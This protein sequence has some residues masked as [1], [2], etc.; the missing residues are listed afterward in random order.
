[1]EITGKIIQVLPPVSGTSKAGNT[2]KKREYVLETQ[3][4]YPKKVFFDFFGD[5]ADQYPLEGGQTIKLS[6]DIESR[7]YNGRWYTS[8]RGW[9]A[10][11]LDGAAPAQQ[12]MDANYPPV[13]FPPAPVGEPS[14]SGSDDLP[15]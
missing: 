7:E 13:D 2:W 10:E 3:E 11:H 1:M 12:P 5:R 15:F 6:F 4:T 9:K 8:I 14:A